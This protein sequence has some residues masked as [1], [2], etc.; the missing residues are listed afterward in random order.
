MNFC[1]PFLFPVVLKNVFC[2]GGPDTLM[3]HGE[4]ECRNIKLLM[5]F[6]RQ[7]KLYI[8]HP[9]S[10]ERSSFPRKDPQP[11][12]REDGALHIE[13][14]TFEPVT[15]IKKFQETGLPYYKILKLTNL[16]VENYTLIQLN[17]ILFPVFSVLDIFPWHLALI[18]PFWAVF[19]TFPATFLCS[20]LSWGQGR[21][22]KICFWYRDL[23]FSLFGRFLLRYFSQI[24]FPSCCC[25]SGARLAKEER[26]SQNLTS[27]NN[28]RKRKMAAE[29]PDRSGGRV[30]NFAAEWI[31]SAVKRKKKSE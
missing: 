1:S 6:A 9:S 29:M 15:H 8:F 3:Q 4:R 22:E 26:K 20:P 28:Y 5:K 24:V 11:W 18:I 2:A 13:V 31:F 12:K 21:K 19:R 27:F 17:A 16:C 23:F 30:K 14:I 10:Q 25:S 7:K